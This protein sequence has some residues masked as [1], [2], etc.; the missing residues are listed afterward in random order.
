MKAQNRIKKKE[1]IALG[2][3]ER[4]KKYNE[5]IKEYNKGRREINLSRVFYGLPRV[6]QLSTLNNELKKEGKPPVSSFQ[7]YFNKHVDDF[8]W[9]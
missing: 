2:M 6:W 7:E 5:K 8:S 4:K 3:L 9:R 1:A